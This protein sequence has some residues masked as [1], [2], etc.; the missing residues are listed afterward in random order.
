MTLVATEHQEWALCPRQ[1]ASPGK[2]A[3]PTGRC[4]RDGNQAGLSATSP[5]RRKEDGADSRAYHGQF[6]RRASSSAGQLRARAAAH[7]VPRHRGAAAARPARLR[8]LDPRH[9]LR[10]RRR[11]GGHRARRHFRQPIRRPDEGWRPRLV[12]RPC[13]PRLRR[14]SGAP[15]RHRRRLRG[16]RDRPNRPHH[17]RPGARAPRRARRVRAG[18]RRGDRRRLLWRHG[19]PRSGRDRAGAGRPHRRYLR[20]RRAAPGRHRR[21]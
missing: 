14:R 13:R 8:H 11:T 2:V 1:P 18:P 15:P 16:R 20:G 9:R 12:G 10:P 4:G 7:S 6:R 5:E 17:R 3:V 19:G 21:A